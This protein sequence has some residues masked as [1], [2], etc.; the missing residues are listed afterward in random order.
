MKKIII[1]TLIVIVQ[2]SIALGYTTTIKA[3]GIGAV[4]TN[5]PGNTVKIEATTSEITGW[6]VTEGDISISNNR[7]VTPNSNVVIEAIEEEEIPVETALYTVTTMEDS[8][9]E[10]EGEYENYKC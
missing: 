6:Q 1:A 8:G 5:K 3:K 7:Y 10:I 9:A 4:I 2:I